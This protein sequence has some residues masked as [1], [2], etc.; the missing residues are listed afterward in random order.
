[1]ATASPHRLIPTTKTQRRSLG[2]QSC[3]NAG[4]P[5]KRNLLHKVQ[6]PLAAHAPAFCKA[7]E[8]MAI[9]PEMMFVCQR[10]L[11]KPED[12]LFIPATAQIQ[13]T[14]KVCGLST[15]EM[16]KMRGWVFLKKK[17]LEGAPHRHQSFSKSACKT[18]R[19]GASHA[20]NPC[21]DLICP[22]DDIHLKMPPD[23][24]I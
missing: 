16:I 24:L 5:P 8:K 9:L 15:Q 11:H 1:L 13:A 12:S 22:F 18:M 10:C 19:L 23:A 21:N 4:D 7:S 3:I 2:L 14:S 20:T 17:S 6:Q